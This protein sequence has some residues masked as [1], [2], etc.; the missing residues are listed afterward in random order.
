[1]S[2]TVMCYNTAQLSPLPNN[3]SVPHLYL[4]LRLDIPSSHS[5]YPFRS[6][7]CRFGLAILRYSCLDVLNIAYGTHQTGRCSLGHHIHHL[8]TSGLKNS[9]LPVTQLH[10]LLLSQFCQRFCFILL[11]QLR[12]NLHYRQICSLFES[13]RVQES[14]CSKT[15]IGRLF[16]PSAASAHC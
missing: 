5:F 11:G 12:E 8:L 15:I 4:I 6:L 9:V 10:P 7:P 2:C 13:H 16:S 3:V 14:S 1:M